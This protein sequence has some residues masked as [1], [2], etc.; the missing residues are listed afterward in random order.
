M[1]WI[2]IYVRKSVIDIMNIKE[3]D[4]VHTL[5]FCLFRFRFIWVP[6]YI[7]LFFHYLYHWFS[8]VFF[9][10]FRSIFFTDI[11]KSLRLT[12]QIQFK[13]KSRTFLPFSLFHRREKKCISICTNELKADKTTFHKSKQ[14]F[15]IFFQTRGFS[16]N[17][18]ITYTRSTERL[19][20]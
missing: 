16:D 19:I 8:N 18:Y 10:L 6:V 13:I 5:F 2:I 12:V 9:F 7:V 11:S 17:L 14:Y 4:D 1:V 3:G 15:S 20:K